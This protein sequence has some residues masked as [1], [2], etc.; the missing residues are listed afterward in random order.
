MCSQTCGHLEGLF[1]SLFVN[2]LKIASYWFAINWM[3]DD[4]TDEEETQ[5]YK[6][7][8]NTLRYCHPE[9]Q[10]ETIMIMAAV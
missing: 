3:F 1:T 6:D 7:T 8:T 2:V 4:E 10:L 9:T 5:I